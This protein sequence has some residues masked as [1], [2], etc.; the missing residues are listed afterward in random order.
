MLPGV[1][2]VGGVFCINTKN[3]GAAMENLRGLCLPCHSRK[4][5]REDGALR[6]RAHYTLPPDATAAMRGERAGGEG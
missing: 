4:T 1:I 2:G 5:V 3:H 6:P